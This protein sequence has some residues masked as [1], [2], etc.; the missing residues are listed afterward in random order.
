MEVIFRFRYQI[1]CKYKQKFIQTNSTPGIRAWVKG[2][3][4]YSGFM[5]ISLL[6]TQH[7]E[8]LIHIEQFLHLGIGA[9]NPEVEDS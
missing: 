4:G 2:L 7:K 3:V 1:I 9:P 5:D 8:V 6:I